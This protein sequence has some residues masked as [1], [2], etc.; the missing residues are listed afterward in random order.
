MAHGT[1]GVV[2]VSGESREASHLSYDLFYEPAPRG[3]IGRAL[4]NGQYAMSTVTRDEDGIQTIHTLNPSLRY[5]HVY[6]HQER[7]G[8]VG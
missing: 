6:D 5:C 3:M 7:R 8:L 1:R 4:S 2:W